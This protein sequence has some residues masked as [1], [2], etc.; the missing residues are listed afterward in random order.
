M[1]EFKNKAEY[2][3][4]KEERLRNPQK[5]QTDSS[6]QDINKSKSPRV[7]Q[8]FRDLLEKLNF[9]SSLSTQTSG[10]TVAGANMESIVISPSKPMLF[11]CPACSDEISINAAACPKCGEPVAKK[12]DEESISS[13]GIQLPLL[14]GI[15]GSVLLLIG[16]FLPMV[17]LPISGNVNFFHGEGNTAVGILLM[18]I[19][20]ISIALTLNRS[21]RQLWITGLISTAIA[22][23][24]FYNLYTKIDD[25][26]K[27]TAMNLAGNP[28]KGLADVALI[29]MQPQWGWGV[30]AAG[31]LLILG[32]ASLKQPSP[33]LRTLKIRLVL[34]VILLLLLMLVSMLQVVLIFHLNKEA[35]LI[36]LPNYLII[37]ALYFYGIRPYFRLR[38]QMSKNACK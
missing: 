28:F 13:I 36:L 4:W 19:A 33:S 37:A 6:Q 30:I 23:Q 2:E 24:A 35:W 3:K 26:K 15:L 12:K 34:S 18:I 25:M 21:F 10:N 7:G 14:L 31:V 16:P 11:N 27:E 20:L 8:N 9:L 29:T 5:S 32:A 1:A 22:G 17:S 38:R